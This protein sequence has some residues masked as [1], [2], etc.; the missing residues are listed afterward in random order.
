MGMLFECQYLQQQ[1]FIPFFPT[2][3]HK[4]STFENCSRKAPFPNHQSKIYTY[5]MEH[6]ITLQLLSP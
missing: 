5:F 4:I 2:Q 6:F 1:K 3:N